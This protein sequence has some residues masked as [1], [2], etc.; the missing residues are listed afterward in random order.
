LVPDLHNGLCSSLNF[1]P[2]SVFELETIA[3]RHRYS[4]WQIEKHVFPLIRGQSNAAAMARVI[5]EG[6]RTSHLFRWPAAG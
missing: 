4:L 1:E 6:E 5:I 2:V 3:V